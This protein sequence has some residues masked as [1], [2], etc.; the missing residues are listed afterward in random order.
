MRKF[1]LLFA[2]SFLTLPALSQDDNKKWQ[3]LAG[4]V[5]LV[6]IAEVAE[7]KPSMGFW[8]GFIASRQNVKYKVV[9]VLKGQLSALEFEVEYDVVKNGALS[10]T[11]QPRLSPI[12]FK[13]GNQLILFLELSPKTEE[14][15]FTFARNHGTT[16]A[17]TD[18]VK[19]LLTLN[20][21]VR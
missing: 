18:L 21:A 12:I 17:D 6:L 16:K 20:D 2:F 4:K 9:K 11:E 10:D 5:D 19:I 14:S 7:V 8:S 13:V 3:Q 1:L 15:F